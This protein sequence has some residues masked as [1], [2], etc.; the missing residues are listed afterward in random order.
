MTGLDIWAIMSISALLIALLS[1]WISV[2]DYARLHKNYME[3]AQELVKAK[4]ALEE[5]QE[6]LRKPYR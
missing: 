1:F 4:L 3:C 5:A 6:T 2:R